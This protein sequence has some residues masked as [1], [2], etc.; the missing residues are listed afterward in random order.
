ML[1]VRTGHET[2]VS[3]FRSWSKSL[4]WMCLAL[5]LC[6]TDLREQ[7]QQIPDPAM[8]SGCRRDYLEHISAVAK[9]QIYC[10][11]AASC[12]AKSVSPLQFFDLFLYW[13]GTWNQ[14][15]STDQWREQLPELCLEC[16]RH[17]DKQVYSAPKE[18]QP[19]CPQYLLHFAFPY[20]QKLPQMLI[21]HQCEPK[22]KLS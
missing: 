3:R 5:G 22:G 18:D 9:M 13:E 1:C 8:F 4:F 21:T 15:F 17:K 12:P 6:H 2:S 19:W 10:S 20:T 16:L 11:C 14:G 7:R